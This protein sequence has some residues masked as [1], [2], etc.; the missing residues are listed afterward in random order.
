[1]ASND[2]SNLKRELGVSRREL[3]RRGAVVG[4]TLLWT[5]PVVQSLSPKAF[6]AQ[7]PAVSVCCFC[8]NTA[9]SKCRCFNGGSLPG[10]KSTA[11]GCKKYCAG[12]GLSV[13]Q[14]QITTSGCFECSSTGHCDGG[15][16]KVPC[17]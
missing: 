14:F 5:A 6:A 3:M 7:S 16:K 8:T 9:R 13:S 2:E 17:S 11:D 10:H 15:C 1:M 12:L 4:G